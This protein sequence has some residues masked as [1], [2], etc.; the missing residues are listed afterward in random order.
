MIAQHQQMLAQ[1]AREAEEQRSRLRDQEAQMLFEKQP[2]LKNPQEYQK[3]WARMVQ[4][5][6]IKGFSAEELDQVDD[7]RTY[8]VIDDAMKYHDLKA[9][10]KDARAKTNGKPP[11]LQGST[12]RSPTVVRQQDANAAL[13]RLRRAAHERRFTPSS[14]AKRLDNHG[15]RRW[16]LLLDVCRW[17]PSGD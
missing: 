17:Q 1:Q 3:F 7:H 16:N 11:L 5:A 8:G 12:R 9:R 2:E 14:L 13:A 10:V 4:Y 6:A 15:R